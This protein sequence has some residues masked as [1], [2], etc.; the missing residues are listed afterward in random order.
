MSLAFSF[1]GQDELRDPIKRV[2][3]SFVLPRA[4]KSPTAFQILARS[5]A[6]SKTVGSSYPVSRA[7][8]PSAVYYAALNSSCSIYR[9]FHIRFRMLLHT[10]ISLSLSLSFLCVLFFLFSFS[11]SFF[12]F[13]LLWKILIDSR[14]DKGFPSRKK[15]SCRRFLTLLSLPARGRERTAEERGFERVILRSGTPRLRTNGI[16]F[17]KEVPAFR[18]VWK[19]LGRI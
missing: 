7:T 12:F 19:E 4:W 5:V 16:F 2:Y 11:F 1:Y 9:H 8:V 18:V 6:F 14:F 17:G 10:R 13:F 15:E 3:L